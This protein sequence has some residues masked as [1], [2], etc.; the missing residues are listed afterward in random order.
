MALNFKPLQR[1]AHWGTDGKRVITKLFGFAW[2]ASKPSTSGTISRS[3][4][5]RAIA[6]KLSATEE[7]DIRSLFDGLRTAI[8]DDDT[9]YDLRP[10]FTADRWHGNQRRIIRAL[11]QDVVDN[12]S[13][14]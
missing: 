11:A 7:Q 2:T 10:H 9:A 14:V 1:S 8:T 12:I 6:G 3:V 13:A 5:N 4:V